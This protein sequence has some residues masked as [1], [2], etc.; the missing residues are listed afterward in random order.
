M[1]MNLFAAL[2][3]SDEVHIPHATADNN[4]IQIMLQIISGLLG[5]I[6][7]LVITINAFRYIISQGDSS[8]T[9]KAKNGILYAFIG[10]IVCISTFTIVTFVLF[11]VT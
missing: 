3:N 5:A 7:L 10:L 2:L 1:I 11:N 4:K 6:A 9:A 8:Q